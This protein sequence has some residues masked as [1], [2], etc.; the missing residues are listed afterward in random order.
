MRLAIIGS[1]S[2][3]DYELLKESVLKSFP[4][5][6]LIV[7]GGAKGADQLGEKLADEL[8]LKTEIYLPDWAR[9]GKGAGL[10]R[11]E[12]IIKNSEGVIAFWDG[13]SKGTK[14]SIEISRSLKKKLVVVKV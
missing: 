3:S 2:F 9:Y 10:V 7:S 1:R 5:V 13:L 4:N 6:L 11:N 8:G 12:L 14:K